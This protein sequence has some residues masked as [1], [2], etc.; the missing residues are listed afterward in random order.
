LSIH[1][2][3][4][5]GITTSEARLGYEWLKKANGA[6]PLCISENIQVKALMPDF[7]SF[8]DRTYL[9]IERKA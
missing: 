2:R 6:D 7:H 8:D 5:P 1:G 4:Q 3:Q 9:R